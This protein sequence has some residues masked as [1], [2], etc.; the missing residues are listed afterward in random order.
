MSKHLLSSLL[1]VLVALNSL[2][3]NPTFPIC[4]VEVQ[5]EFLYFKAC[6]EQTN[7]ILQTEQISPEFS[8][9]IVG[10]NPSLQ[11]AFRL[12]GTLGLDPLHEIEIR[13]TRF[14]PG[15]SR[16]RV[17]GTLVNPIGT[18]SF[19]GSATSSLNIRYT[20]LEALYKRGLY[21]FSDFALAFSG[22]LLYADL[23]NNESFSLVPLSSESI[24]YD[25]CSHFWGIGPELAIDLDY[26]LPLVATGRYSLLANMR[27]ALL[28]SKSK[29]KTSTTIFEL[30]AS[31]PVEF[32]SEP[33]WRITP[34]FNA[35]AGLGWDN[36]WYKL[37]THLEIGYEWIWTRQTAS[38]LGL[39]FFN[40]V[41]SN[42][43]FQGP[44]AAL[45]I[46]F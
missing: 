3:A 38:K 35:R 20:S 21:R 29:K 32:N 4:P 44:Y 2:Q 17:E 36:R 42:V 27:G 9:T 19:I 6:N 41:Y 1:F 11:P 5:A 8:A 46:A 26:P 31:V 25:H 10:N 18:T 39:S 16:K 33:L 30:A 40:T 13:F 12:S 28:T 7:F 37:Q 23:K 22:G 43:S 34:I 14:N 24:T 15:S 45:A